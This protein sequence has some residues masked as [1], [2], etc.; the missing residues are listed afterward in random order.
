MNETNSLEEFRLKFRV[1][2]LL[3]TKTPAWSWSVRP[4]QPTVGS[5]ILSLNRAALHLSEVSKD[6][7][8]ELSDLISILESSVKKSFD[9]NIMNYMMLMMVD[10]HVHYHVIP[11]YDSDRVFAAVSWKDNG[12][13]ALPVLAE[14]QHKEDENLLIQI[15]QQLKE[16]V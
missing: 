10:H 13:P 9:Y 7:M 12:W 6:E 15:Q 8:A 2:E 16:N 5:G 4:G 14:K 3:I 1:E 11:R